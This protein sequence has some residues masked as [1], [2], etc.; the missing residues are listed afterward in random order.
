MEKAHNPRYP[1]A[2]WCRDFYEALKA[3]TPGKTVFEP[4]EWAEVYFATNHPTDSAWKKG[5]FVAAMAWLQR[6][7]EAVGALWRSND[8]STPTTP[9]I[10]PPVPI[11]HALYK[12]FVEDEILGPDTPTATAL[13]LSVIQSFRDTPPAPTKLR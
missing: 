4:L 5:R 1:L 7:T 3:T 8:G 11:A 12:T 6:N 9:A 2:A 13:I 10:V